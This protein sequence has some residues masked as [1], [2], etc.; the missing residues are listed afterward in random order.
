MGHLRILVTGAA[1]AIGR[2][3]CQ[4]LER[5]GH[6]VYPT[7][8]KLADGVDYMDVTSSGDVWNVVAQTSPDAIVHLAASKLA[9][10]GELHPVGFVN[11]NV[12]GTFNV[13]SA[14][15][16]CKAKLI[17][18]STCKAAD[19]ETVYGACKLIGE[20]AVLSAGGTVLRFFNVL[21]CGPSVKTIWEQIPE[22]DPIPFTDCKRYFIS[23]EDAVDL[24]VRSL[25]LPAGRFAIDPGKPRQM[26]EVAAALYPDR[27]LVEIPRR[28]GDRA[29]EPLHAV[30]E[31]AYP[32]P[33]TRLIRIHGAHDPEPVGVAVA[34]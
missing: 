5:D 17:F 25:E 8:V 7:D 18:S 3:L 19:P 23:V 10:E 20:R 28:R 11:T 30:C 15:K 29:V 32:V 22:S 16:A 2:P 34:A 21:E 4:R 1:G 27:E 13:V 26:Q 33:G 14:A 9:V 31:T 24:V 6:R 12:S